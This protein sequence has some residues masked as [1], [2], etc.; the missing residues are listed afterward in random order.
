MPYS[1][2]LRKIA[3]TWNKMSEQD[4]KVRPP[5]RSRNGSV[6]DT[7]ACSFKQHWTDITA[8][9]TAE[10]ETAKANY[11]PSEDADIPVAS[12]SSKA[13]DATTVS[14]DGKEYTGKKRGRKSN[15]E[16]AAIEAEA[17][18]KAS[19]SGSKEDAVA[20]ATDSKK[21]KKDKAVKVSRDVEKCSGS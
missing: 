10:Y 12:A 14:K 5:A 15:A 4:K 18:A 6:C 2:V 16:K 1:D 9:K 11:V 7:N 3:E 8:R 21:A 20:P 13:V 19:G 17:A